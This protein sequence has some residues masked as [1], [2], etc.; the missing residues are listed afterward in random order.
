MWVVR[1]DHLH[2]S[3]L[4]IMELSLKELNDLYYCVGKTIKADT[5]L[6]SDNDLEVLLDILSDEILRMVKIEEEE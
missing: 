5:K 1:N 2:L 3:K 6:I 4:K